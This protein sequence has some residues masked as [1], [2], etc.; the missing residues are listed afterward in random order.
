M[1]GRPRKEVRRYRVYAGTVPGTHRVVAYGPAGATR[2]RRV[3]GTLADADVAGLALL[4]EL[5][6]TLSPTVREFLEGSFRERLKVTVADSTRMVRW[7]QVNNLVEILGHHRLTDLTT[8][9]LGDY[10]HQRRAQGREPRTINTE[11]R[12]LRT[13]LNYGHT[14]LGLPV[15]PKFPLK[16]REGDAR[17]AEPWT[18]DE[19]RSLLSHTAAE[20]PRLHVLVHLLVHSGLRKGEAMH[21]RWLDVLTGTG[22]LRVWPHGRGD[23]WSTKSRKA[24]EV[25]V[26]DSCLAL[27][28]EPPAPGSKAYVFRPG[29]VK[30]GFPR[31]AFERAVAACGLTGGAH[32]LRH[33]YASHFLNARPDLP[34]L[35]KI[36]GHSTARVTELYGHLLPGALLQARTVVSFE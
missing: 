36:L 22:L 24:R 34:L 31:K 11:L 29:A 26:P 14:D 32:K 13:A 17:H 3:Y 1:R 19:V 9:H 8:A 25:P 10:Q 5:C 33:T 23:A 18:A 15:P 12:V 16:L 4:N 21:L 7:Y 27:L 20:A 35:G 6:G 30:R 2:E 28:G